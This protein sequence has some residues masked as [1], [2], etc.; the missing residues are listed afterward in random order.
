MR[1]PFAFFLLII[2]KEKRNDDD[3]GAVENR[4]WHFV[5]GFFHSPVPLDKPVDSMRSMW[6]ES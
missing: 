6:I 5:P 3:V 2:R 4:I 1:P